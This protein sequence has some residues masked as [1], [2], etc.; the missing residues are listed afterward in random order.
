VSEEGDLW[1]QFVSL[2]V[3]ALSME[4][5][6]S[7]G[8][9]FKAPNPPVLISAS[10]NKINF[11]LRRRKKRF[12]LRVSAVSYKEFAESALEETRKR[13]VLEPSHLQVY[14]ITFR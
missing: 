1:F 2:V 4:F 7:I 11:T 12:L 13:I 14:A 10:P 8:S 3:M 9:C 6:F 5:G